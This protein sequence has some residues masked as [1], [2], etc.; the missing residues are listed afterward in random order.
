MGGIEN[1]P[2]PQEREPKLTIVFI[3]DDETILESLLVLLEDRLINVNVITYTTAKEALE[4]IE[5][6]N[7]S[8][9]F[10]DGE[11]K[12]DRCDEYKHGWNVVRK[13]RELLGEGVC[14]VAFSSNEKYNN[15]MLEKGAS[16]SI[17]KCI[18]VGE[19]IEQLRQRSVIGK[20]YIKS[21]N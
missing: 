13:I 16:I 12:K 21:N 20:K 19:L 14:I 17:D 6:D 10:V 2:P 18:G 11:L 8:I 5:K 9:V 4:K 15:N 1:G 3:D 7:P